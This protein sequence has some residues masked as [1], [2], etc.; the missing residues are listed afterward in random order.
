MNWK[1]IG[2]FSFMLFTISV[3]VGFVLSYFTLVYET[4]RLTESTWLNVVIPTLSFLIPFIIFM[5]LGKRQQYKPYI[6]AI[7]VG[8]IVTFIAS[9]F[10]FFIINNLSLSPLFM[11]CVVMLLAAVTG[12]WCGQFRVASR[13]QT[14]RN[15][16]QH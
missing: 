12:V 6:H 5:G 10:D 15:K 7:I 14:L 8:S 4:N 13:I 9:I 3:S 1:Q 11:D 16:R 2:L